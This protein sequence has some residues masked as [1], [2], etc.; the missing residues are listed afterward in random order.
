M[1][2]NGITFALGLLAGCLG[3]ADANAANLVNNGSF[4]SNITGWSLHGTASGVTYAVV[5]TNVSA[6]AKSMRTAS[7]VQIDNSIRQNLLPALNGYA[8]GTRFVT[9]FMVNVP[10]ECGVRCR[11]QLTDSSGNPKL[12]LA[13]KM[14]RATNTWVEVVLTTPVTWTGTLT[15]ATML[16]EVGQWVNNVFPDFLLD[17][18]SMKPDADGDQIADEDEATFGTNPSLAD[19]D[20]DGMPDGWEVA[21]QLNPLVNDAVADADNDGFTNFQE[22]WTATSPRDTSVF[23]GLTSNTNASTTAKAI[24]KYLALLPSQP[25]GLHAVGQHLSY[26]SYEYVRDI[27]GLEQVSGKSPAILALQYDDFA[28]PPQISTVNPFAIQ[29]WTNGGLVQIKWSMRNPWSG[30]FY[31]NTNGILNDIA[32]LLN[33]AGSA[34]ANLAYNQNANNNLMTWLDEVAAGLNELQTNGVVVL[35]RPCSEMNGGWFWWGAQ[36]RENYIG[37]WRF[38]HDYF[39]R[40]KGLNNL[41]WVFESDSSVHATIPADYYYPGNDVVDVMTHNLY[42]DTW[43]LPW[44]SDQV[45]R[46]Y[47][48]PQAVPQAGSQQT[49]DGTWDNLIFLDGITNRLPRLSYFCAWSSFTNQTFQYR[50]IY[51]NPNASNLMNHALLVTRDEL[52]F[53][54]APALAITTA[55][56]LPAGTVGAA[57]SQSLAAS[58]GTPPYAWSV[59]TGTLPAGVTLSAMGVL[60]G[61]P[62]AAGTINFTVQVTDNAS[63]TAS[64]A[65]SL[66][67]QPPPSAPVFVANGTFANAQSWAPYDKDTNTQVNLDFSATGASGLAGDKGLR[68][69]VRDNAAE[70]PKQDILFVLTNSPAYN[71]SNFVTRF[72]VKLDAPASVRCFLQISSGPNDTTAPHLLAEQVVRTSNQWVRIEGVRRVTWTNTPAKGYIFFQV[73]QYGRSG[74]LAKTPLPDYTIDDVFMDIDTDGDG[75]SDAEELLLNPPTNPGLA[76]SDGDGLPDG[77]EVANGTLPMTPDGNVDPDGDWFS[78]IQEYFAATNPQDSTQRPGM[79]SDPQADVFTRTLLRNLA[80]LPSRRFTTPPGQP[81]RHIAVG[82]MISDALPANATEL[83]TYSNNVQRLADQIASATGTSRWP[84]ILGLAAEHNNQ[85]MQIAEMGQI[86]GPWIQSGGIAQIKFRPWNPWTQT[87]GGVAGLDI[88]N[89]LTNTTDAAHILFHTWL[90]QIADEFARLKDPARGGSTNAVILFRPFSEMNGNWFWW[91]QL[92]Q[93]DY[94]ALW[95]HVYNYMT[96]TR[97]LHHLLWVYESASSEHAPAGASSPSVASDYYY[98][99]DD[100]VDVMGHNL[101]S[102][103][104][105]LN[106]DANAVYRRYPKVTGVPQAGSA[107]SSPPANGIHRATGS[108]DNLTYLQR[109]EQLYPRLSFFIVWNSFGNT[110]T[111]QFVG[112]VDSQNYVT[113]MTTNSVATRDDLQLQPTGYALWDSG[114]QPFADANAD[115][116]INFLAYAMGATQPID[117][118]GP[119]ASTIS[120]NSVQAGFSIPNAVRPDVGYVVQHS[121]DLVVWTN[122]AAKPIGGGWANTLPGFSV[123][124]LNNQVTVTKSSAGGTGFFR[125]SVANQ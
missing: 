11:L 77:W 15:G 83:N 44:E 71:G 116:A 69:T 65:I 22:Y 18:I 51:G 16:F 99:G 35:W 56:A 111:N 85:P 37:L 63:A 26:P 98:P 75:L 29:W 86:A 93:E 14:V 70:G 97:G 10:I 34:P 27:T 79:P 84:A 76:D 95:R 39:T 115:G 60:A 108:F 72:S 81:T 74:S 54:P 78:N 106:F 52:N 3:L 42:S 102:D 31:S 33:P 23:P 59:T 1:K 124:T 17:D 68:V 28:N 2:K 4:E 21:N 30:G 13:E 82:Q 120:A 73:E 80:L 55:A 96:V 47:P 114:Y 43:V 45:Y 32:G 109:I 57:Y 117:P 12:I 89:L 20:G 41:I 9:R 48:K 87:I 49:R 46:H 67:V 25:G 90:A 118:L 19:T 91:G 100:V 50:A 58:G 103:S 105:V 5:T 36:K 7:R 107:A 8:N 62:S 125:F 88:P 24:L 122:V 112:I 92:S 121:D 119:L 94:I 53:A 40:V 66:T 113:L 110:T 38:M 64:L 61:T 6:G 104:W 123:S 101:Y